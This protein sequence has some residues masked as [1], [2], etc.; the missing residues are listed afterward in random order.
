MCTTEVVGLLRAVTS[1]DDTTAFLDASLA[2]RHVAM[3]IEPRQMG[4]AQTSCPSLM[5]AL[6]Y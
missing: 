2:D 1:E 3:A 5:F 4:P 6:L